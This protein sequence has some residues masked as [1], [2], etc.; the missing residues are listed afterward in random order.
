MKNYNHSNKRRLSDKTK[1]IIWLVVIC[2]LTALGILATV[3]QFPVA[4]TYYTYNGFARSI[5]LGLDLEGGIEATYEAELPE[6][7]TADFGTSLSATVNRITDLLTNEGFSEALVTTQNGNQIRIE[8]A[9]VDDPQQI[10][11][12][13]G[14]PAELSFK[15]EEGIAAT[16]VM[17][18]KHIK[19]V[20]VGYQNNQWGVVV[21]FTTEGAII[22]KDLTTEL[23]EKNES[24][25]IYLG[26]ELYS[27]P[28]VNEAITG[29]S[30]FISG[31]MNS[32]ADAE[33]FKMKLESGTFDVELTLLSSNVV[34]ATLGRDALNYSLIAGLCGFLLIIIFM[35]AFYRELGLLSALSLVIYVVLTIFFLQAI[36][37]VQLTLPGIAGIILSLG[38]AVDGNVVIFERIK[39]EYRSGKSISASMKAGF[40][41]ANRSIIDSNITTILASIVLY[42]LGTGA[43][44][45]FAL[46]LLIGVVVSMFTTL[47]VTRILVKLY[48]PFNSTNAK[49]L[50]L[51]REE[52]KDETV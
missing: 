36:P 42:I 4:G 46:T 19:S 37:F 13:I 26:D 15:K 18:S 9:D 28:T 2:A 3:L 1:S 32:Q 21:N 43:I 11:D 44:K 10:L 14:E 20:E 29:G 31:S 27:S 30:T 24:L 17:T 39:A 23:A 16:K 49:R 12:V 34:S 51:K 47:V 8:V 38:M 5:K 35:C 6:G 48:L 41:K 45:G 25:Y 33:Q 40:Q 7:S 22:F 50:S 52:I